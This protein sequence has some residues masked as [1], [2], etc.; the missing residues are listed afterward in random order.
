M[1]FEP[2]APDTVQKQP[3]QAKRPASRFQPFQQ[4]QL[5]GDSGQIMF[6]GNPKPYQY[7]EPEPE[8]D[9]EIIQNGATG[10]TFK[11][12][13][14]SG[15]FF[16]QVENDDLFDSPSSSFEETQA[17]FEKQAAYIALVAN[18]YGL[19]DDEDISEFV[20]DRSRALASAQQRQPEYMQEFNRQFEDAEGFFETAGVF[21]SNPRAIGRTALT[22]SPNSII[23]L[24]AAYGG[25]KTGAAVG[26]A[27]GL[28]APVP[29]GT[30]AGATA[31]GFVGASSGAFA[32]GSMVEIGAEIDGMMQEAGVDITDAAQV[33]AALQDNDLM[34]SIKLKAERKGITTASVDALFQLFGG[35][36]L[37]A[38]R[39]SGGGAVKK[40]A[41]ATGDVLTESAGEFTGEAAGQYAKD[42]K[43]N[44]KEAALEGVSSIAQSVGQVGIGQTL[45][46]AD[47]TVKAARNQTPIPQQAVDE[48]EAGQAMVPDDQPIAT[49]NVDAL[50]AEFIAE[51]ESRAE[52]AQVNADIASNQAK[53]IDAAMNDQPTD[54]LTANQ[55]RLEQR[56]SELVGNAEAE[57][58]QPIIDNQES[59]K[60]DNIENIAAEIDDIKINVLREVEEILQDQE[61]VDPD[62]KQA[63]ET[64]KQLT[65]DRSKIDRATRLTTFLRSKG[66]LREDRGELQAIG[67]EGG[68]TGRLL[69]N[70]SGLD[71]D[72][73]G[74]L[75]WQAG[76]FSERP[77]IAEFLYA[78][79]SDFNDREP[80]FAAQDLPNIDA[81]NQIDNTVESLIR[82]LDE[83]GV[84]DYREV[85]AEIQRRI[86][87]NR[88]LAREA[89]KAET[90]SGRQIERLNRRMKVAAERTPVILADK[91]KTFKQGFRKGKQ[92]QKSETRAVQ[93]EIIKIIE[94]SGLRPEDKA[95][96]TRKIKNISTGEQA[97]KQL[98]DIEKRI[99]SLLDA[100]LRRQ[101]ISKI[102]N[103]AKRA[104]KSQTIAADYSERIQEVVADIELKKRRPETI[105]RLEKTQQFF[106]ANPDQRMPANVAKALETLAKRNIDEIKTAELVDFYNQMQT[107]VQQGRVKQKMK[108]LARERRKEARL[109]ELQG[110]LK[111]IESKPLKRASIG[112]RLHIVDAVKNKYATAA[113]K[114]RSVS[115]GLNPMDVFFDMLD[116]NAD[117][118]GASHGIFKKK[119][120]ASFQRYLQRKES[121]TR[122]VKNLADKLRLDD[123]NFER[124]G[125]YA[126][127]QQEGGV[128]KL[129]AT[130][131]PRQEI[132]NLSLTKEE[133]Q[134]YKLMR[135]KLDSMF[136]DINR[137]MV[138]VYN[139]NV[140][141]VS[142]YFPFMTDFDA[143]NET[144]IQDMVGDDVPQ[145]VAQTGDQALRKQKKDV[146]QGFAMERTGGD[147]VI[148]IDAMNVFM[149]HVDNAT[150]LIDM[151]QDI[152]ELGDLAQSPEFGAMAGDMAQQFTVDWIALLARKGRAQ[153]RIPALDKLR[154]NT[155]AAILGYKLS[156]ILIQP[157]AL[158]DGA[159]LVG[160][161]YVARG[162]EKVATS[163]EWRKFL[164]DNIPELRERV[165]DDPAYLEMGGKGKVAKVREAGFWALKNVDLLTASSVAAGA[166]I[167]SVEQRGGVVDLKN[168]DP[169]ALTEAQFFLRRTQSSAFAKDLPQVLSTG[170]LFGNVSL[171]K[172]IFQ[173]QSFMLN[174]WSIIKH[175]M[176]TI[177]V[178]R[179]KTKQALNAAAFLILANMTE[180]GVRRLSK[181][182][183]AALMLSDDLEPWEE[184]IEKES[185][186]TAI[187]NVPFVSNFVGSLEYGSNPV[188]A[189]SLMDNIWSKANYARKSKDPDKMAKH[190]AGAAILTTG[191]I[192]GVPGTLQADQLVREAM[193]DNNSSGGGF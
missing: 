78:L 112:E 181:E 110:R 189:I 171:D 91:L 182:M 11:A 72:E 41:A 124:I 80:V 129:I 52:L 13:R 9:E 134:F 53:L 118:K 191:V 63:A 44:F 58:V 1:P 59:I 184:T 176:A 92:V 40:T 108:I 48:A 88:K 37:K 15:Q 83:A 103:L 144:Q 7:V 29:F 12:P 117:Y 185:V 152:K 89:A 38:V 160:G 126:A 10:E 99:F 98:P 156:S 113:N 20:A 62:I 145:L 120:D 50:E 157:T 74:E 87:A 97:I 5:G 22:Q 19:V 133:M 114:A 57:A 155:G 30:A 55:I 47:R 54:A 104:K 71:F 43:I 111:P 17:V 64:I 187:N 45:G 165:G 75:A 132:D 4:P 188:P 159:A 169:A 82:F 163:R 167:R 73:A 65:N 106:E 107:L 136:P 77:T 6:G 131:I 35:R 192:A 162:T 161:N 60:R 24:L 21:L 141:Q 26:G 122:D 49:P 123:R 183:I 42:G 177:G 16:A 18:A 168:P 46:A 102:T 14:G 8:Q 67:I 70:K 193:T 81:L 146:E 151:A 109:R 166:Y 175:D 170:K 143:I 180:L 105:A 190:I 31:G 172:L 119:I 96:F 32:G 100:D 127:A 36:M 128:Q 93:N 150:Y 66:G 34:D 94:S 138:D 95:K 3:Q 164:K 153:G 173:F 116:N 179:G 23:P 186:M 79:D 174:R 101:T 158:M 39:K 125:V 61:I 121:M 86:K 139:K 148:R 84:G 33:L 2:L 149:K 115:L 51:Q 90:A 56:L 140:A 85:L 25:A 137:V 135:E 28:I 68:R 142:D 154:I 69:N 178:G 147:Q 27:A 76:Y 130:G